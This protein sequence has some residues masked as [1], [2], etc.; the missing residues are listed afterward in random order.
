MSTL[1][2]TATGVPIIVGVS[3]AI[4]DVLQLVD[5]VAATDCCVLIEG[6]SGT[7][8]EL[9]ARRLFAKSQRADRPFIPVNCAGISESLFESQFFGHVRGAFTG[10]EQTMLGVFRTAEGGTVFLDEICEFPLSLAAQAPPRASRARS[11]AR[12][13]AP[14]GEG[15]YAISGRLEPEPGGD[16]PAWEHSAG[17]SIIV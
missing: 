3:K 15:R 12:G 10:A 17:T 16:G 11:H 9:I 5:Q 13:Q 1:K 2:V 8:K 4:R 7:G 6:E 14:A